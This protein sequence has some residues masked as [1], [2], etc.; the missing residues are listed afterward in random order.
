[1]AVKIYFDAT[2]SFWR[3][4]I[5]TGIQ[6]VVRQVCQRCQ[7]AAPSGVEALP[8]LFNGHSWVVCDMSHHR[9]YKVFSWARILTV[10]YRSQRRT[11]SEELRSNTINLSLVLRVLGGFIGG[12]LFSVLASFAKLCLRFSAPINFLP[13][14]ILVTIEYPASPSRLESITAVKKK[15]VKFIAVIHDCVPLTHPEFYQR[16]KKFF[17]DYFKWTL[18]HAD[19]VMS[20]S[21]FSKNE[22][23]SRII[24]SGR[25]WVDYFHLG[26]DFIHRQFRSPGEKLARVFSRPCF[27]M[28]GTVAPHKNHKQVLDAMDIL[29]R[30]QKDIHFLIIGKVGWQ[31]EEFLE[32]VTKHSQ[33][34]KKL[35][36]FHELDDSDL[37]YAYAHA[38]ALIAASYVEGF[39]L[40]V[41][42]ALSRG[43]SVIASDIPV[44][45]EIAGTAINFFPLENVPKLAEIINHTAFK[46]RR[47]ISDWHW[48]SWTD[49]TQILIKKV[50]KNTQNTN[51]SLEV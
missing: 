50:I 35:F 19:G 32:R 17:T 11:A 8:V 51:T 7:A 38:H 5:Q 20:V 6:R 18:T 22:I 13:G 26:G 10:R 25:P 37:S 23:E 30:D 36:I 41:V 16:D 45:R 12:L 29:W 24:F 27:L 43:L 3:P 42:E 49:S 4:E 33:L 1:M 40:P 9:F 21:A 39:G 47:V 31:A 34:G 48:L 15:G 14:D 46:P 28:V 2:E 44:F